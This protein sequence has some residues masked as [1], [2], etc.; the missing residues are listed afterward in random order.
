MSKI[1]HWLQK[2]T[3]NNNNSD[4]YYFRKAVMFAKNSTLDV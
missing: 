2:Q 3:V 1:N 4:Q